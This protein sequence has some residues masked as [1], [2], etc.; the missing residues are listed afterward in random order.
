MFCP[1][2]KQSPAP[3]MIRFPVTALL[4]C[5][6]DRKKN[7]YNITSKLIEDPN[8]PCPLKKVMFPEGILFWP[9]QKLYN[10]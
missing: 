7:I 3:P 10:F 9:N 8:D 1:D 6:Y 2:F 5:K 4:T